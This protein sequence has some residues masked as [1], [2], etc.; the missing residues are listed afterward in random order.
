M[1]KFDF[2]FSWIFVWQ[3]VDACRKVCYNTR[4][5]RSGCGAD[6][7]ALPWGGRGRGFKSRHSDQKITRSFGSFPV[8]ACF[9]LSGEKCADG[10]K[11]RWGK[12]KRPLSEAVFFDCLF[13]SF[14]MGA[15]FCQ[16][17]ASETCRVLRQSTSC[18]TIIAMSCTT[19]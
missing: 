7:S 14:C 4:Y 5:D 19:R 13:E 10:T 17:P 12:S 3:G 9:V 2:P 15:A 16:V 18:S 8:T 11:N 1:H 6:G